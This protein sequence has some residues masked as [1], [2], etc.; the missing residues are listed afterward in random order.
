MMPASLRA[1]KI[2]KMMPTSLADCLLYVKFSIRTQAPLGVY[3]CAQAPLGG[4]SIGIFL[5][6]F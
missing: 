4:Y 3:I 6:E 5:S 1:K 2:K